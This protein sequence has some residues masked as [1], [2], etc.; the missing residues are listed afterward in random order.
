TSVQPIT[1]AVV[2]DAAG[3]QRGIYVADGVTATL[4]GLFIQNGVAAPDSGLN[5]GTRLYGGGIYNAGANLTITGTWILSNTGQF[6]GG[7]YHS[8]GDLIINNSVLAHN[9]SPINAD[10]GTDTPGEGGG[11]FVAAGKALLENNTFV[12]NKVETNDNLSNVHG[13]GIYLDGGTATVL[14][15]IFQSNRASYGDA[16]Y[17]SATATITNDY[18]LFDAHYDPIGGNGSAGMNSITGTAVFIDNYFHIGANSDAKD[19]GT[20][21][22]TIAYGYDFDL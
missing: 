11:L 4:S 15:H 6:G 16:I 3:T 18:N 13:G 7:L 21:S 20:L 1:N 14:N 5:G 10:Q 8:D 12:A 9:F 17:I 19:T 22:V 2:L